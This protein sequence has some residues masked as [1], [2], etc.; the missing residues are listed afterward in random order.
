MIRRADLNVISF[1][2]SFAFLYLL[3]SIP[4]V[5]RILVSQPTMAVVPIGFSLGPARFALDVT[6]HISDDAKL[7][8]AVVIQLLGWPITGGITGAAIGLFF[9]LVGSNFLQVQSPVD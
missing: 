1:A 8:A 5:L 9:R 4:S 7:G 6:S 2:K 3:L